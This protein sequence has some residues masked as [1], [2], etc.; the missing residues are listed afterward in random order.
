MQPY[1]RDMVIRGLVAR[2]ML[3]EGSGANAFDTALGAAPKHG[4]YAGY[5]TWTGGKVSPQAVNFSG[6][7]QY[8][9]CPAMSLGGNWSVSGWAV[10]SSTTT[11][12]EMVGLYNGSME[13]ELG[14]RNGKLFVYASTGFL[15]DYLAIP[16]AGTWFQWA[17]TMNAGTLVTCVNGVSATASGTHATTWPNSAFYIGRNGVN[18][19]KNFSSPMNDVRFYNTTLTP[20]ELKTIWWQGSQTPDLYNPYNVSLRS[21][22]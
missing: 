21:A 6:A 12:L 4:T 7:T 16:S 13:I 22:A 11:E 9:S 1:P 17:F 14:T 18:T 10:A 5:P 2:Y 20:T 19:T 15:S 8:T 3:N